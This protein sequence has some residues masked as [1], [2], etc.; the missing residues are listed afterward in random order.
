MKSI[1]IAGASRSGK[2]ILAKRLRDHLGCE[3]HNSDPMIFA[4]HQ[5][6]PKLDISFA[7]D[8]AATCENMFPFFQAYLDYLSYKPIIFDTHHL[9]PKAVAE[10]KL[11]EK[12]DVVFLGYPNADIGEKMHL[13]RDHLPLHYGPDKMSDEKLQVYVSNMI[14]QSKELQKSC[15]QFGLNFVDTGH[16]FNTKIDQIFTALSFKP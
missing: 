4:F 14:S 7:N 6:F 5:A 3:L 12:Y 10:N 15:A 11:Q 9:T 2:T 1:L 16:N 13:I 8:H